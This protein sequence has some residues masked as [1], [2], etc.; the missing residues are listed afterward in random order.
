[1]Q[2]PVETGQPPSDSP[3]YVAG[4]ATGAVC[5]ERYQI[6]RLLGSGGMGTVYEARDSVLGR[7]VAL[8][9]P[10]AHHLID[11]SHRRRFHREAKAAA[12]VWHPNICPIFDIGEVDSTLY[13][14]MAFIEGK[15]LGAYVHEASRSKLRWPC[16]WCVRSRPPSRRRTMPGSCTSI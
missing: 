8:K 10:H 6:V 14:T 15:P 1:M 7:R 12:R 11:P 13:L 3:A 9:I 5:A 16:A 4:L 2:P